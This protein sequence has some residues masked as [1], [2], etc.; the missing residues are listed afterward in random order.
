MNIQMNYSKIG[1]CSEMRCILL[2]GGRFL[3]QKI[4]LQFFACHFEV[5]FKQMISANF[6]L[7]TQKTYLIELFKLITC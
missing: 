3:I 5:K 6:F 2:D 4:L 1:Y 7:S